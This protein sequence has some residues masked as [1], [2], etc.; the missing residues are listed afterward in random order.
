MPYT[1]L[2]LG[3]MCSNL[4]VCSW[5]IF[6][7][8]IFFHKM[9]WAMMASTMQILSNQKKAKQHILFCNILL[10]QIT[11][12]W[13]WASPRMQCHCASFVTKASLDAAPPEQIVSFFCE[14]SISFNVADSSS[15]ACMIEE[16]MKYAKQISKVIKPLPENGYQET[17]LTTHTSQL[18]N[19]WLLFLLLS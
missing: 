16:R 19:L 14:N 6:C 7:F 3:G 11:P 12:M 15:F 9:T 10:L 1:I 8:S 4:A 2:Y 13:G 5:L 18:S 17:S